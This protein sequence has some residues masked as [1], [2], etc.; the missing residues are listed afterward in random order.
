M[1]VVLDSGGYNSALQ[2]LLVMQQ[3]IMF[4]YIKFNKYSHLDI[5]FI[6]KTN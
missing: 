5:I 6:Q 2:N 4:S 3:E 1:C